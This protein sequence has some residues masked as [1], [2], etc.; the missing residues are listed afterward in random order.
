MLLAAVRA[1]ASYLLPSELICT[2]GTSSASRLSDR[3]PVSAADHD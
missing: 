2:A 3:L 1:F